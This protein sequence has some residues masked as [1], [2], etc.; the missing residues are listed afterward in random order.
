MNIGLVPMSAKPFHLGHYKLIEKAAAENDIT[1][2]FVSFSSRGVKKVTRAGKK[3]E[4]PID[5]DTPVFGSDMAEIWNSLLIPNLDFGGRDVRILTPE[6]GAKPAPVSNVFDVLDALKVAHKAGKT[7]FM[8]PF[9]GTEANTEDTVISIYSDASDI[10]ENYPPAKMLEHFEDLWSNGKLDLTP[11]IRGVGV[12]RTSTVD[13][14]GTKMRALLCNS[15]DPASREAFMSMLPPVSEE[16][17]QQIFEILSQSVSSMCPLS[18]RR[19]K[20]EAAL[21]QYVRLFL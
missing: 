9:A 2:V 20:T 14:S 13:I 15:E 3:M 18:T 5:G 12:A 10:N 21:R 1:L 8:V 17:K 7:K 16:I 19:N 11:A 6:M 4:V